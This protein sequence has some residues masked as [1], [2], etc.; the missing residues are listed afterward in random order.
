MSGIPTQIKWLFP[1]PAA[2]DHDGLLAV[3]ADLEPETLLYAYSHGI[4]PWTTHPITW[5]SPDPRAILD[6][7]TF[8]VSRRLKRIINQGIFKISINR[9]FGEVMQ[10]CAKPAP[11][12]EKTWISPEFIEAYSKLY[13][14]GFAH[15]VECWKDNILVGGIYGVAI[16][17]FFAGESMFFR[18]SNASKV[19][20]AFLVERLKERGFILFDT[21]VANKHTLSLGVREIPREEYLKRLSQAI[22]LNCRF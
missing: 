15:S 19:A 11:G 16:G 3:G 21:Q 18:V 17:G 13:E 9:S 22:K 7:E 4:F 1:P 6:L 8:H 12:R 14:M 5:W 2:A 20:L 10:E